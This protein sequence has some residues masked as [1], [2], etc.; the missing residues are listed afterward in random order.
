[1]SKEGKMKNKQ[2]F[3]LIEILVTIAL[4]AIISAIA[5]PGTLVLFQVSLD[6]Y[7][8]K[9]AS[10]FRITR[11]HAILTNQV[12]RFRFNLDEQEY[13]VE[14]AP[15]DFLLPS[16]KEIAKRED[17]DFEKKETQTDEEKEEEETSFTPVES[18]LKKQQ[19]VPSSIIIFS[20]VS[21]RHSQEITSGIV[22]IY[23]FPD[24]IAETASINL[25]NI[26]EEKKH[27][28]IHPIT[29]KSAIKSGYYLEK[30][31]DR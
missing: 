13:W 1:M 7:A 18:I 27:L 23:F 20:I 30:T 6:S 19:K 24:G 15:S 28:T 3:S 5:I 4:I 31:E 12:V 9:L 26:D 29:G 17:R 21:P 14:S 25:Q 16:K 22:D 8:N 10:L 2:A 11:D